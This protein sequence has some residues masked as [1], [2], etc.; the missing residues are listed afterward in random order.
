MRNDVNSLQLGLDP[1]RPHRAPTAQR[2]EQRENSENGKHDAHPGGI[3]E[4]KHRSD[5][6]AKRQ[7]PA[8]NPPCAI[9]VRREKSFHKRRCVITAAT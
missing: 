8:H 4:R 5:E 6:R 3:A 2:L 1:A 7:R 9:N